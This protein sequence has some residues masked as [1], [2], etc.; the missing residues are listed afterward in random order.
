MQ[1]TRSDV[2]ELSSHEASMIANLLSNAVRALS[3]Y[4]KKLSAYE[5]DRY[6]EYLRKKLR[7]NDS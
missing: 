7:E 1:K 2:V 6:A 4:G 5:C 3:Q